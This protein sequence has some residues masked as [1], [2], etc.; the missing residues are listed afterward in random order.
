MEKKSFRKLNA[1]QEASRVPFNYFLILPG[2]P[3][4]RFL[5]ILS[6][7][8]RHPPDVL[9]RKL[10]NNFFEFF[11][12]S[13]HFLRNPNILLYFLELPPGNQEIFIF[14]EPSVA[15]QTPFGHFNK[16]GSPPIRARPR[17]SLRARAH[18][19]GLLVDSTDKKRWACWTK[20]DNSGTF[21]VCDIRFSEWFP[22]LSAFRSRI[23]ILLPY[24][25]SCKGRGPLRKK[26]QL[27]E[28]D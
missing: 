5:R 20:G 7:F 21:F 2:S 24:T 19:S 16:Q 28:T 17:A 27:F 14:M 13:A 4:K 10:E 15:L 1:I 8:I 9:P 22:C 11:D 23:A 25:C 6:V 18:T 3:A 26:T 12:K